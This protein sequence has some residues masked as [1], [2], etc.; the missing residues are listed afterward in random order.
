MGRLRLVILVA[1]V[2]F[3]AARA[4]AAAIA[5]LSP[6]SR[7]PAFTEALFRLQGELAAVG[8]EVARLPRPQSR[9]DSID[10][11]IELERMATEQ[12]IDAIVD[13]VGDAAPVAVDVWIFRSP[14]V[15]AEVSRVVLEPEA[16]KP[17]AL[18]IRA[19]EVLRAN[20]IEIDLAARQRQGETAPAPERATPATPPRAPGSRVG[21]E[22][23]A[24]ILANLSGIGPAV[25]PLV[26]F[27]WAASSALG[28]QATFA[29]LGTR[30]TI[31]SPAGTVR[32]AQQYGLLGLCYCP[33]VEAAVQP[34]VTLSAG[35][36]RTELDGQA[37]LPAQGHQ[38]AKWSLL[39][40]GSLGV[41][42]RMLDD[43]HVTFAAHVQLAEPYVAI[44]VLDTVVATT[45]RPNLLL[46]LTLGAWL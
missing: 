44:H 8:L 19:I 24:V 13:L 33:R 14:P 16:R 1:V 38:L 43:Y 12:G 22:A 36:L 39:L 46:T 6:S 31:E 11:R 32:V 23:G 9:P 28:A 7:A 17:E 40:D 5:V 21:L 27:D 45:G 25:S 29:G 4:N 42:L 35:A 2:L 30:P 10:W 15:G 3:G 41:R 20:F 18:A 26:G 34:L 37:E